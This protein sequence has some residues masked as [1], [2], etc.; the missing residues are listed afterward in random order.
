M[1]GHLAWTGFKEISYQTI[2]DYAK[3]AL[4]QQKRAEYL[5]ENEPGL[6]QDAEIMYGMLMEY[7]IGQYGEMNA[8]DISGIVAQIIKLQELVMT[9]RPMEDTIGQQDLITRDDLLDTFSKFSQP[10]ED[11]LLDDALEILAEKTPA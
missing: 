7:F 2:K 3:E 8:R 5:R 10:D 6:M 11:E 4:W 9:H 1:T